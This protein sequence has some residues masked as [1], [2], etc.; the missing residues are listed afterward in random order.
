[1]TFQIFANFCQVNGMIN[2]DEP[3]V[4]GLHAKIIHLI[5]F[6]ENQIFEKHLKMKKKTIFSHKP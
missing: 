3:S 5:S 6:Y 1:M 2:F 4:H